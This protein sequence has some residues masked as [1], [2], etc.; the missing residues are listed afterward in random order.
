[1]PTHRLLQHPS[2][3]RVDHPTAY[4]DDLRHLATG[5]SPAVSRSVTPW[6]SDVWP[7]PW[8]RFLTENEAGFGEVR[9]PTLWP[10]PE[11]PEPSS[12]S[13]SASSSVDVDEP[14]YRPRRSDGRSSAA[15]GAAT[16]L[17]EP[18][19][20]SP[21]PSPASG[22]FWGAPSY[23]EALEEA[24]GNPGAWNTYPD[25]DGEDPPPSPTRQDTPVYR[26]GLE[27]LSESSSSPEPS[28][29]PDDDSDNSDRDE[30]SFTGPVYEVQL[31][32]F[33][34]WAPITPMPPA[35]I[36]VSP[37]TSLYDAFPWLPRTVIRGVRHH[38]AAFHMLLDA[39]ETNAAFRAA[40]TYYREREI[41]LAE[42]P[43]NDLD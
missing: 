43:I 37:A 27:E 41:N 12:G 14:A 34:R 42:H 23:D 8:N 36:P 21:L 4:W 22:R 32:H 19:S 11:F 15:S 20:M 6:P 16:P 25:A 18:Q 5:R 40:Y 13:S 17:S 2:R 7:A 3:Q 24:L 28:E 10:A 30:P 26:H 33:A 31:E 38:P 29:P 39:T 35:I 9:D 1:M